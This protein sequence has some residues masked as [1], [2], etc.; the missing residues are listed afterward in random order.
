MRF[1]AATS[2][3]TIM[4]PHVGAPVTSGQCPTW[5]SI[6]QKLMYLDD[7]WTTNF[8]PRTSAAWASA[9]DKA[10]YRAELEKQLAIEDQ[11]IYEEL[12]AAL[13]GPAPVQTTAPTSGGRVRVALSPAVAL[14]NAITLTQSVLAKKITDRQNA[15]SGS[16][17]ANLLDAEIAALRAE[18]NSLLAQQG[19]QTGTVAPGTVSTTTGSPAT[20]GNTPTTGSGPTTVTPFPGTTTTSGAGTSTVNDSTRAA[21]EAREAEA[22]AWQARQDALA[23]AQALAEAQAQAEAE[24]QAKIDAARDAAD[25]ARAQ[26]ELDRIRA[27]S[28]APKSNTGLIIGFGLFLG[29]LLFF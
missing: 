18:L 4:C 25:R 13:N 16:T 5:W 14:Q 28:I 8:D 20:N 6:K 19:A 7:P 17:T 21:Q 1:A 10:T 15:K 22:R 27:E 2:P 3:S 11:R 29:K 24:A 23:A 26:A 12:F 9:G